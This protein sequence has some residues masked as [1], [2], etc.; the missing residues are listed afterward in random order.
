MNHKKIIIG[1]TGGTGAGKTSAL[2][3]LRTLGGCVLDCDAVYHEMLTYDEALRR[4]LFTAFGDIFTPDGTLDR[5]K[6]GNVVFENADKLDRLN[7]IIYHRLPPELERRAAAQGNELVGLDAVNLL[8]SGLGALCDRTVA[9]LADTQVRVERIMQRDGISED[10]A[11]L[12]ISAQPDNAYYEAA[13][14]D[15]L[16][17]RAAKAEEFEQTALEFFEKLI[18][19]IREERKNV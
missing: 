4:D 8:Q 15:I 13:C 5:Q 16:Y 2:H 12:R 1:I 3:A 9:V 10:Y 18:A 19:K 11:R 7:Q 17:N 14:T 6:L